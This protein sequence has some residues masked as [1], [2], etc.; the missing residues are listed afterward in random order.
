MRDCLGY[1]STSCTPSHDL[2]SLLRT[3]W[4]YDA[5]SVSLAWRYNSSLEVE[6]GTGPWF[7]PFES[8]PSYSY[9]DLGVGYDAPFNARITLAVN[10]LT[11]KKPPIVGSDIGS[12]TQN[13][14]NTFPQWYDTVGRYYSLGVTFNF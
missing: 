3:T 13:S 6:P 5:L 11:D 8:I 14:G 12:T 1:Y 4:N 2:K 9:F 10:N 7:E